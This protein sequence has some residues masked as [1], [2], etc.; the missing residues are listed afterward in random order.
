MRDACKCGELIAI[1]D[2]KNSLDN[3]VEKW[4]VKRLFDG[5]YNVNDERYIISGQNKIKHDLVRLIEKAFDNSDIQVSKFQIGQGS[6]YIWGFDNESYAVSSENK[7]FVIT[8]GW[9][10]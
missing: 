1:D 10:D 7:L 2:W 5:K 4:I 3:T 8:L 6:D 9:A